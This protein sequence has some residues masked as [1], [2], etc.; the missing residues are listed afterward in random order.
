MECPI[1]GGNGEPTRVVI[2]TNVAANEPTLYYVIMKYKATDLG[3]NTFD[4][5][6]RHDFSHPKFDGTTSGPEIIKSFFDES[7]MLTTTFQMEFEKGESSSFFQIMS[8]NNDISEGA[9][10][11]TLE[12]VTTN[13]VSGVCPSPQLK[14]GERKT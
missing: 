12:V 11:V 9:E 1:P 8:H 3:N 10:I 4:S 2:L 7:G 6:I 14:I 13:P 5:R